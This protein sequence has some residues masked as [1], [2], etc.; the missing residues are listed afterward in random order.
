MTM[1]DL[2]GND[3]FFEDF[4]VGRQ[5]RHWRGKTI[6]DVETSTLTTLVMNTSDGHFNADVMTE[7][8]FGV[9]I[10]F[11]GVVAS[12]VYGIASQ[13]TA[14]QAIREEGI[15]SIRFT[16]AT[17]T[18]DTLYV[19]SEVLYRRPRTRRPI[20]P[21]PLPSRRRQRARRHRVHDGTRRPAA[22]RAAARPSSNAKRWTR[23]RLVGPTMHGGGTRCSRRHVRLRCKRR[24]PSRS[25][26][27]RGR[28]RTVRTRRSN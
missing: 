12:I 26:H 8:E 28:P 21:G 11:G 15:V 10:A 5:F 14:E 20:R 16:T 13:D 27:D 22:A 18:G 7:T 1:A 25:R 2:V 4:E 3:N 23:R 6:T 17:K 9:P 19:S 24:R